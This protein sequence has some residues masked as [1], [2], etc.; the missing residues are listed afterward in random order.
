M[1]KKGMKKW[2]KT[3]EPTPF[4][5]YE[6]ACQTGIAQATAEGLIAN[7]QIDS[8]TVRGSTRIP[9]RVYEQM[10]RPYGEQEVKAQKEV[11]LGLTFALETGMI[12]ERGLD[13]NGAVV[14]RRV[15]QH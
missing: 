15:A 8:V 7:G 9:F 11:R 10:V 4:S 5:A 12:V 3:A 14:Y 1:D 6:F 13:H 2:L